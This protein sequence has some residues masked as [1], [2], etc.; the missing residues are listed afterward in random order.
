MQADRL[1]NSLP[2]PCKR[3][4]FGKLG[5]TGGLLRPSASKTAKFSLILVLAQNWNLWQSIFFHCQIKI[6]AITNNLRSV[7][8]CT[9]SFPA[10]TS[11]FIDGAFFDDCLLSG[12]R[13]H[14]IAARFLPHSSSLKTICFICHPVTL[15]SAHWRHKHP[16]TSDHSAIG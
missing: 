15:F 8:K 6:T 16:I 1:G 3:N 2:R 7:K 10:A 11:P 13:T 14:S 4:R 12:C 9:H 5:E